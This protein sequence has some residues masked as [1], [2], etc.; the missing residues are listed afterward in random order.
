MKTFINETVQQ[1]FKTHQP[2]SVTIDTITNMVDDAVKSKLTP[3]DD[4]STDLEN[5][6]FP[7]VPSPDD[8]EELVNKKLSEKILPI[9]TRICAIEN[10]LGEH[11]SNTNIR[12]ESIEDSIRLQTQ[13]INNFIAA[14]TAPNSHN[15]AISSNCRAVANAI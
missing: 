11:T 6:P 3:F 8:I 2:K 14:M 12:L 1:K 5:D 10:S 9:E 4:R 13:S 7:E 15:P